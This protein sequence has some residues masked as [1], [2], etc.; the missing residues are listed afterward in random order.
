MFH[1]KLLITD[2]ND[3]AQDHEKNRALKQIP[4]RLETI[5]TH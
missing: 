1:L 3:S 5:D 4:E 2:E